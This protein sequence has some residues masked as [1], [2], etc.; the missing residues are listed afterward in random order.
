MLAKLIND[1]EKGISYNVENKK[2]LL[3]SLKE[4]NTMIGNERMKKDIIEQLCPI[5]I[6]GSNHKGFMINMILYGPPGVG[7]TE[8]GKILAKII[9]SI[10]Y[11]KYKKPKPSIT[12][13][14]LSEYNIDESDA[15]KYG[16]L[17]LLAIGGAYIVY[18]TTEGDMTSLIIYTVAV[19]I[20]GMY[21][22][23]NEK[24]D[25]IVS[26]SDPQISHDF[27]TDNIFRVVSRA[28]L[29]GDFV[30]QSTSKTLKVLNGSRGGV[31]FIDEAYT[32]LGGHASCQFGRECLDV[33]NK[34]IS[35]HPNEIV[36]IMAGYEDKMR[37][38]ET[39]Q[40]GITRR[41]MWRFTCVGYTPQELLLIFKKQLSRVNMTVSDDKEIE[42]LFEDNYDEMTG[43][44]GDTEKLVNYCSIE[45]ALRFMKD[46]KITKDLITVEDIKKSIVRLTENKR[47]SISSSS[48][49][50]NINNLIN[51]MNI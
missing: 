37:W 50:Y 45:Y 51:N 7:K 12:N 28:D 31:L 3:S 2:L 38:L 34:F 9:Y 15:V 20:M 5:L 23:G 40:E 22:F 48:D 13:L 44:G 41:F 42:K 46:N 26:H 17:G 6:R 24:P 43:F 25:K 21:I 29:V 11:I 10:G 14:D 36:I 4:L 27:N 39:A 35:E 1:L 30:G 47:N 8:I 18:R 33:I 19:I 49:L 32:I 16:I